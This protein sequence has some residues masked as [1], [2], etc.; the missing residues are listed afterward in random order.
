[1]SLDDDL[2]RALRRTSPDEGFDR[3]VVERL[4]ARASRPPSRAP[5]LTGRLIVPAAAALMVALGYGIFVSR[6]PQTSDAARAAAEVNQ[7]L[8]IASRKLVLAQRHVARASSRHTESGDI[9]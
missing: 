9:Q 5:W 8:E 4:E 6:T 2:Q 3:R 1:M 7:A